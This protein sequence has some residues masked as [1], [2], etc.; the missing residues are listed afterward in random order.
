M[1]HLLPIVMIACCWAG[2]TARAQQGTLLI[3]EVLYHARSGEAEYIELYNP[4]SS[5]IE[6]SDYVV[7]RWISDTFGAHYPLPSYAVGAHDYVALTKDAVS[8]A[9]NYTVKYSSKVI[10]CTLPPYSNTGGSVILAWSDGSVVERLDYTPSMHSPLLRN[11]AGIALERRD[12]GKPCNE[13]SNWFSA[14]STAGYGTPGYTNSQSTEMLAEETSFSLSST[15]V[16]PDGDGYQDDLTVTFSLEATGLYA[17]V[18]IWDAH[19]AHIRRLVDNALLGTS[20]N[21]EWD[22]RGNGGRALLR[23][24]YILTIRL[25]NDTGTQQEIRR[26]VAIV[27]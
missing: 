20:G 24:R 6:L 15:L 1:K 14:A 26:T 4:T 7:I 10:E 12:F 5:P 2:A 18:D 17:Q 13:V 27:D 22:G 11:K 21:I 3:S 9:S 16:S 25:Y 8:V 19:G 23:G